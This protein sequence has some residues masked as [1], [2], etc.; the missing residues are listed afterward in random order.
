MY[1]KANGVCKSVKNVSEKYAYAKLEYI[2]PFL[3]NEHK[4]QKSCFKWRVVIILAVL[5][6]FTGLVKMAKNGSGTVV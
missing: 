2:F 6:S 4:F 3:F 1:I 5:F